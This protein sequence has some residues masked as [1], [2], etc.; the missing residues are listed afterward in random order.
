MKTLLWFRRDLRLT[1][2]PALSRAL[3]DGQVIPVYIHAPQEECHWA[4]GG[5]SRWW[6]HHSL[7]ALGEDLRARGAD[8]IICQ[9][10][11]LET[12]QTLIRETG[13]QQVFWNRLYEPALIQRDKGIKQHLRDAGIRAESFNAALLFEPWTVAKQDGDPYKVFTPFWKSCQGLGVPC[14]VTPAPQAI[15]SP[16][17]LPEGETLDSLGLLP[18]TDWAAGFGKLWRPGEAG[19][20]ERL[21]DFMDEAVAGY[22]EM[23]NR[24]DRDGSSRLSP[25]LHFGEIGPR[26]VAAAC[27]VARDRHGGKAAHQGIDS[28]L[29]EIGWREFAHHLIFHFPATTDE[30]LDPR[31]R[32]VPWSPVDAKTL[33]AWRRGHTGIPLVDAAMRALWATGWMHNRVRM[34]VASLLTKNLGAHWLTG[35]NWFWDTLV[36][37][38]LASNTLGWQWT[39]GCGADAAPY[40][41]VFNPVLQGERFDPNGDY[42]RQWVPELARLPAKYIHKPWEAPEAILKASDVHLG[43]NYP[44]PRVDLAESR[45]Q[46]LGKWE[47]I[48]RMKDEG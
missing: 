45:R 11:S 27:L 41:R 21:A 46:A 39:A 24:P 19:A 10:P 33:N 4:P 32:E 44:R 29:R 40:F 37:A 13:A 7:A 12:L 20:L 31:F 1:D 2:N 38:D 9:G 34:V 6:L 35:A 18:E 17:T 15:G 43:S 26:Q 48:K 5:A 36:D 22:D 47:D 25:Y 3:E 8:L 14:D 23:R 30:P 28:F 42:V 16:A